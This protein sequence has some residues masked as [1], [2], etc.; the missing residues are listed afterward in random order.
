[1]TLYRLRKVE[2]LIIY[3]GY[4]VQVMCICNNRM[5]PKLGLTLLENNE[6]FKRY[7]THLIL[8]GKIFNEKDLFNLA[9][10]GK[11]KGFYGIAV[12]R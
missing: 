6:I 2:F 9:K 5:A 7:S 11:R 8:V 12:K 3:L 10:K 4:S 1:M